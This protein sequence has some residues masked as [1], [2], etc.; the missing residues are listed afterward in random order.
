[1]LKRFAMTVTKGVISRSFRVA[2]QIAGAM[3]F[4]SEMSLTNL[5]ARA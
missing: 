5:F 2:I 3:I 1:M 4:G